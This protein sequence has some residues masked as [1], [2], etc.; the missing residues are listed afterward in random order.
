MRIK[1]SK[2]RVGYEIILAVLCGCFVLFA[3]L[4]DFIDIPV[5]AMLKIRVSDVEAMHMNLFTIQATISVTGAAIISLLTGVTSKEFYGI[6]VSKFI[7]RIYPVFLKHHAVIIFT[8][9]I[10]F[11]DYFAVSLRLFD[12]SLAIF[13]CSVLALI[14]LVRDTFIV[15]MGDNEIKNRIAESIKESDLTGYAQALFLQSKKEDQYENNY[16]S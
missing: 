2:K 12:V 4:V 14:Y 8:F 6:S 16:H 13:A 9:A 7:T 5:F 11:V 15:F 1:H 10:T 3:S